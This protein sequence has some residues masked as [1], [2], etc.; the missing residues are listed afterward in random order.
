V[1]I[2]GAKNLPDGILAWV[3]NNDAVQL[4]SNPNCPVTGANP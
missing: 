3:L 1:K 4:A 2:V